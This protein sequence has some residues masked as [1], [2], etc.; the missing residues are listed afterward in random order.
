MLDLKLLPS[1]RGWQLDYGIMG[2]DDDGIT[3]RF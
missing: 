3:V 1:N 2:L